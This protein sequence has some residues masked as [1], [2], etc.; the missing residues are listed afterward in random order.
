M[1]RRTS[2]AYSAAGSGGR[3][4]RRLGARSGRAGRW[5][6]R[7]RWWLGRRVRRRR[8]SGRGGAR[9]VLAGRG[10]GFPEGDRFRD[11]RRADLEP[12]GEL[13]C[14]EA[15]R[16]G[17]QQTGQH[18]A[19]ILGRPE[20]I[21]ALVN[22]SSYSAMAWASRPCDWGLPAPLGMSRDCAGSQ[23]RFSHPA[24][25]LECAKRGT[26]GGGRRRILDNTGHHWTT[27]R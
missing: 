12:L 26:A 19:V 11:G 1:V 8:R 5:T 21:K 9:R 17:G 22:V 2:R 7:W 10:S 23:T 13:G 27:E 4:W 16:V 24:S 20:A 3:G 14:A 18:R 15:A 6:G 25:S